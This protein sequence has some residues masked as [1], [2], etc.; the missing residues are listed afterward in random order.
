MG[1]SI[2]QLTTLLRCEQ[3][4]WATQAT[5]LSPDKARR[6]PRYPDIVKAA[7]NRGIV[8]IVHFTRIRGLK[9]ILYTS[10]IKA[11][12]YL[13]HDERISF[14]YEENA[15]DRSRDLPWHG[16]INLSVTEINKRVFKFSQ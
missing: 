5:P 13:P 16:Y 4:D 14:V 15:P 2:G 10:A 12:R 6:Q 11:R 3:M 9:G 8:R 7:T 1:F